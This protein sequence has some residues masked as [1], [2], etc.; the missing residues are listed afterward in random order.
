MATE[1]DRSFLSCCLRRNA[2]MNTY[3]CRAAIPFGSDSEQANKHPANDRNQ[4]K[5]KKKYNFSSLI[6]KLVDLSHRSL[7]SFP[8][9]RRAFFFYFISLSLSLQP[10]VILSVLFALLSLL[11]S[12][13][14][15]SNVCLFMY[16][17]SI[18]CVLCICAEQKQVHFEA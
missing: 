11:S 10:F 17:A 1:S 6:E 14:T 5:E 2:K 9:V 3:A 4:A 7:I 18:V 15:H 8:V 16:V 13:G 12:S